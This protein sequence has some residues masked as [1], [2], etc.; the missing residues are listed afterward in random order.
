MLQP[1]TAPD[2]RVGV[3]AE[4]VVL[5]RDRP[6]REPLRHDPRLGVLRPV[7]THLTPVGECHL[8]VGERGGE[9]VEVGVID[10]VDV[11]ADEDEQ[12]RRRGI[13][14]D[15]ERPAEGELLLLDVRD[16]RGV[17]AGD[18]EGRVGRAGV[19]DDDLVGTARLTLEPR[20]EPA[21]VPLLVQASDHHAD[22]RHDVLPS[23]PHGG[24]QSRTQ[25][26]RHRCSVRCA[27]STAGGHRCDASNPTSRAE[28][29]P[30]HDCCTRYVII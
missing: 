14:A 16:V 5:A 25:G 30:P 13:A 23:R 8:L 27:E 11:G 3:V 12:I 7:V 22:G 6:C 24:R 26:R 19:H 29:P 4:G 10:R 2:A 28:P 1:G 15:V 21:D 17:A 18:V 9:P 20:E